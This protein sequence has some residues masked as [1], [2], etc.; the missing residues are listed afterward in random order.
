[1]DRVAGV[2]S[3][4]MVE[5]FLSPRPVFDPAGSEN[6]RAGPVGLL[7]RVRR[8][9]VL[10]G[11]V[12]VLLCL[13]VMAVSHMRVVSGLL[14]VARFVMLGGVE[15]VL[16]GVLMVLGGFAMMLGSLFRHGIPPFGFVGTRQ[17]RIID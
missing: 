17:L 2:T 3:R 14:M 11:F 10:G 13:H 15:M 12:G 9:V 6:L 4:Q 8:G 16:R 1:R 5:R 7:L